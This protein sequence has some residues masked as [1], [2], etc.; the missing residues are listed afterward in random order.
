MSSLSKRSVALAGHATSVAL[1]PEF[2]AVLDRI[3]AARSLSKA[4]LL[5]EIDA[6]R[7]RR[8]LA[9]ACRLLALDWVAD[10]GRPA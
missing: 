1:E 6:G 8:P 4:Q 9:S 5:A 7:G 3:A 10:H 2:W